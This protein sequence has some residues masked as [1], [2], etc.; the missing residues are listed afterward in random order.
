MALVDEDGVSMADE[1][2]NEPLT[3][4]PAPEPTTPRPGCLGLL[5]IAIAALVLL[6]QS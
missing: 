3:V 5:G 6:G 1:E 4:A 2:M